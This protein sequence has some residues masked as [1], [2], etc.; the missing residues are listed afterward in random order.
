ME[1]DFL[2]QSFSFLLSLLLGLSYWIF[3]EFLKLIRFAFNIKGVLLFIIDLLFMIICSVATFFFSLAFLNGS[4]RV[5]II[6]GIATSFFVT[7]FTIG[8]YFHKVLSALVNIIKRFFN[9]N[10]N[11]FKIIIKLLLKILYKV[12]YNMF[13]KICKFVSFFKNVFKLHN[14]NK[15]GNKYGKQ[16]ERNC[17]EAK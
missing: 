2:Q 8:M 4:V 3:Y 12:L 11:L 14:L 7:H 15:K 16:K 17:Q 9:K 10:I 1:Y 6:L 13:E 5:F